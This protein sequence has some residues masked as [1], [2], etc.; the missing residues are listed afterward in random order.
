MFGIHKFQAGCRYMHCG[1]RVK[2]SPK[3]NTEPA[4]N[5][6]NI[7]DRMKIDSR[8]LPEAALNER[9]RPAV[10]LRQAGVSVREAAHQCELPPGTVVKRIKPT[11]AVKVTHGH[12]PKGSGRLLTR[13]RRV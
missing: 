11:V 10:K 3:T 9:R 4:L 6:R 8:K 12:W 5:K 1:D 2:A 13:G 7:P